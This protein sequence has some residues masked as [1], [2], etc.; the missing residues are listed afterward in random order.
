MARSSDDHIVRRVFIGE[1]FAQ[2]IARKRR[3]S[4]RSAEDWLAQRMRRPE[5]LGEQ[6]VHQVFRIV[7]G[8]A[9]FFQDHR[10]FPVDLVFGETRVQN[11]IR[12]NIEGFGQMLI[13]HAGVKAHHFLGGKGVEHAAHA[14]HF[15]GNIFSGA[16]GGALEHHV[17]DEM[18]N[19]VQLGRLAPRTIAQPN[20]HRNGMDVLHRL[21]DHHEP[22]R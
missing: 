14:I 12:Q 18:R 21:G 22:V 8:H 4:F 3:N 17:L 2:R 20:S 7:L 6:F 13:E 15:T 9:D 10:F 1:P 19:A 5:I 16:A 11:H